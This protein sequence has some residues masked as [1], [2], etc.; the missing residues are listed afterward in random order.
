MRM[1]NF[2]RKNSSIK[3]RWSSFFKRER[4]SR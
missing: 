3:R 2:V 1:F 4:C